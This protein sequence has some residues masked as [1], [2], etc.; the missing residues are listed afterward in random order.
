MGKIS[1]Q[2]AD[3]NLNLKSMRLGERSSLAGSNETGNSD[4]PAFEVVMQ[5]GRFASVWDSMD[6]GYVC[7]RLRR[8]LIKGVIHCGEISPI[9]AY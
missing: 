3:I 4:L 6:P 8:N 1:T 9:V 7:G 2:G 5:I